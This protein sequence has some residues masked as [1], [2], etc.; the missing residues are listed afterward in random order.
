MKTFFV[1]LLVLLSGFRVEAQ[2]A[3]TKISQ[4]KN[5]AKPVR[6]LKF[7]ALEATS[8]SEHAWIENQQSAKH[9]IKSSVYGG[10]FSYAFSLNRLGL[11]NKFSFIV[12]QT[13]SQNFDT[14][15]S[16]FHK[17][18]K[19]YG[20]Q[21]TIFRPWTI[22]RNPSVQLGVTLPITFRHTEYLFPD[23][24]YKAINNLSLMFHAGLF[25]GWQVQSRLLLIQEFTIPLQ[26]HS[27]LWNAGLLYRL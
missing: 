22:E 17:G 9:K 14:G 7:L 16:Y 25:L 10:K 4:I 5:Y 1:V 19:T 3:P 26:G 11:I 6:K 8:W 21:Y 24:N 27:T 15:I 13:N 20:L 23:A 12:A 18:A 2:K